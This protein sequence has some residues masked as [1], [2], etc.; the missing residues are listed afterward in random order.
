MSLFFPFIGA[1]IA[2]AGG[3]KL[4]GN[5]AYGNMFR[6]IGWSKFDMR[7]AAAAEVAGGMMLLAPA[8]RRIGGIVLAAA[9]AAV[10]AGEVKANAPKLAAPRAAL[11]LTALA[12]IVA[13]GRRV[14]QVD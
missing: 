8:T 3:D 11:L 1:A 6:E 13:P 2:V 5:K 12:A 4:A 14:R 9:S 7:A 10:L